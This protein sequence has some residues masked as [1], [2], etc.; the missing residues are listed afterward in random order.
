MHRRHHRAEECGGRLGNLVGR[1]DVIDYIAG[2][3]IVTATGL[4][5]SLMP[6]ILDPEESS[7]AVGLLRCCWASRCG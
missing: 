7:W 6:A 1:K 5:I 3:M 2:G 4:G